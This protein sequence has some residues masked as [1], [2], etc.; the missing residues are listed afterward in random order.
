MKKIM[1][2]VIAVVMVLGLAGCASVK[3]NADALGGPAAAEKL[4]GARWAYYGCTFTS[5]EAA[6][7]IKGYVPVDNGYFAEGEADRGDVRS[8]QIAARVDATANLASFCKRELARI[9]TVTNTSVTQNDL[10][11]VDTVLTGSRIIDSVQVK[12][13][14]YVLMFISHKDL[15]A[16]KDLSPTLGDLVDELAMDLFEE[17][18]KAAK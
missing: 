6:S 13:K 15:E 17:N 3:N 2:A 1:S 11:K 9:A 7:F 5:K 12:N 16:S 18:S 10:E 8:S 14:V 4:T